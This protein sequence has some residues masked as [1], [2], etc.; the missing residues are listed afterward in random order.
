MKITIRFLF[1]FILLF[2]ILPHACA[3]ESQTNDW[4]EPTSQEAT[5]T[6][7][8]ET[9]PAPFEG[10]R[11]RFAISNNLQADQPPKTKPDVKT[12]DEPLPPLAEEQ[13]GAPGL[14]TI[15]TKPQLYGGKGNEK[16]LDAA[17]LSDGGFLLAGFTEI[18]GDDHSF[19]S[20]S[21]CALRFSSDGKKLWEYTHY[22]KESNGFFG[23]AKE[24]PDG[25]IL[26]HHVNILFGLQ[27]HSLITL[28]ADGELLGESQMS[29]LV[30]DLYRANDGIILDS[31]SGLTKYDD[32]LNIQYE[33]EV[34]ML[35]HM[36]FKT[37]DGLLF[38][39]YLL[40][41]DS[42]LGDAVVFMMNESGDILWDLNVQQNAR[43]EGS[44]LLSNGD[45][46]CTGFMENASGRESG[47]AVR[48]SPDGAI[49][50]AREYGRDGEFFFVSHAYGLKEGALLVGGS[51][52]QNKHMGIFVCRFINQGR[53]YYLRSFA[54][55]VAVSYMGSKGIRHYWPYTGYLLQQL[56]VLIGLSFLIYLVLQFL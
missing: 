25:T 4:I 21:A 13:A 7:I 15:Q 46:L 51:N 30:Y 53:F 56:H 2:A 26:L 29:S 3:A 35:Q 17:P 44:V 5:D 39:G 14:L 6:S 45:Y 9:N 16:M 28:S 12:D 34:A 18:F 40:R 41:D 43:F 24:N 23:M 49:R 11:N 19:K 22:N 36:I 8:R 50:Y 38:Y 37:Q 31:S 52:R 10:I 32:D 47:L 54:K 20:Q 1:L 48:V 27:T 42:L 33:L 55:P